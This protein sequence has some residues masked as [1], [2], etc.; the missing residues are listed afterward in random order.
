MEPKKRII[1]LDEP[2]A[3]G[4]QLDD[5]VVT[6]PYNRAALWDM[7]QDY[8]TYQLN[9]FFDKLMNKYR[10]KRQ[11]KVVKFQDGGDVKDVVTPYEVNVERAR[12]RNIAHHYFSEAPTIR[13]L[14]N[15]V[16]SYIN[17]LPIV[18]INANDL[19]KQR[20]LLY[21]GVAPTPTRATNASEAL[22]MIKAMKAAKAAKVTKNT[23]VGGGF[24]RYADMTPEEIEATRIQRQAAA[25]VSVEK[26][27]M[28]EPSEKYNH[29][30]D[31]IRERKKKIE[32][33]RGML[34]ADK[35]AKELSGKTQT[36][37]I[38]GNNKVYNYAI[39]VED[40]FDRNNFK[41]GGSIHIKPENRGKFNA[42]KKRTGKTTE[43]LTHSKNPLTRKRAIFAQN[44]RK[45]NH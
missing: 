42:T 35:Y 22:Q 14:Y 11:N 29:R 20:G 31:A 39:R 13:N 12:Q 9:E 33:Q 19:L 7:T 15:G 40:I 43:E 3:Y 27:K 45:W 44:A 17:S 6:A 34:A 18:G 30:F 5:V 41:N 37:M 8:A 36:P 1:R 24:K 38:K 21:T 23:K 10:K 32:E 2:I 4:T 25:K 16:S 26:R 28:S